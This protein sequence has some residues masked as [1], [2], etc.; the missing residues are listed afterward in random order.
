MK[1]PL[2]AIAA[3][4]VCLVAGALPLAQGTGQPPSAPIDLA[5]QWAPHSRHE[6][7]I[8]RIPGAE[9]GD[10]A[11]FPLNEAGKLK[12]ETWDASSLSQ[13]EQQARPHPAQYSMRG[14]GPNFRMLPVVD[15]VT[16][17][18]VAYRITN[19]FGSADRTIWMD[20]RPHPS[21]YAAH[22]KSGFT[23]GVWED[24]VLVAYTTHME[25]GAIRR[26]GAHAGDATART[27]PG[28]GDHGAAGR[29]ARRSFGDGGRAGRC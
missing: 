4:G 24:D 17:A 27:S 6:D 16:S 25:A 23:T 7:E 12:A 22:E 15:P 2:A 20:G 5:G 10:Y 13:P 28:R 18:L 26:N 11:G 9:L 21:K 19:L 29:C 14:P 3:L 8:H 1:R